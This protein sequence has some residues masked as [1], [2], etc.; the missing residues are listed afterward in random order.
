MT[1]TNGLAAVLD[2]LPNLATEQAYNELADSIFVEED[3][4]SSRI[5][6]QTIRTVENSLKGHKRGGTDAPNIAGSSCVSDTANLESRTCVAVIQDQLETKTITSV[7]ELRMHAIAPYSSVV[8]QIRKWNSYA[9]ISI[10]RSLFEE[11]SCQL[12]V[13]QRF[14]D[15]IVYFGQRLHEIEIAPP[16]FAIDSTPSIVSGANKGGRFMG[17]IRFMEMNSRTD[18][19]EPSLKWSIRQT[20]VFCTFQNGEPK[21]SWI[22]ISISPAAEKLLNDLWARSEAARTSPIQSLLVLYHFAVCN[23]RPYLI[24][25]V[26]EVEE[27][28]S[29]LLGMTPQND[30]PVALA[31]S[32]RRQELLVLE[33]RLLIAK[34]ALQSTKADLA[35]LQFSSR[36]HAFIGAGDGARRCGWY[37]RDLD[38]TLARVEQLHARLQ[39]LINLVSSFLDLSNGYSLRELTLQSQEESKNMRKLNEKMKDLA[40]KN[41]EEAVTVT[42]LATLTL[43]YLPL[44]VV[45]NFF[46]TSFVGTGPSSDYIYV[47]KDWWIL[48]VVA[49]P[50][51]ALTIYVWRVWSKLKAKDQYPFWWSLLG[52][53]K[54]GLTPR[55]EEIWNGDLELRTE[56]SLRT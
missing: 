10:S 22:F 44:T 15:Y 2:E 20:A 13:P 48:F 7:A 25:L 45:S 29:Q 46:S 49:V 37:I 51:T 16:A 14:R 11:L 5:E 56:M 40:E 47:T 35:H 42:V 32:E 6:I 43:I 39:G 3:S 21:T 18:V 24:A 23:W 50:L 52:F 1:S 19:I 28:E 17:I 34:L 27:H 30:G 31:G 8:V 54:R 33:K 36:D 4:P 26:Y 12:A 9:Q 38:V 55:S 53:K 41:A